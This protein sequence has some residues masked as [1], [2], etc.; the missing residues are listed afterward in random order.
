MWTLFS[1]K[2]FKKIE[3]FNCPLC[4]CQIN[5]V[6]TFNIKEKICNESDFHY[7]TPAIIL[8]IIKMDPVGSVMVDH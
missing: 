4:R 2:L 7:E 1:Y 3:K 5:V 6:K 8:H